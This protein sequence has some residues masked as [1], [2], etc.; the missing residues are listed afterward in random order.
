M[1]LHS[2]N[3]SNKTKFNLSFQKQSINESLKLGF[4]FIDKVKL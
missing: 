4:S 3:K 1:F 2:L